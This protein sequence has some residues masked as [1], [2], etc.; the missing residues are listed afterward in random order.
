MRVGRSGP[1]LGDVTARAVEA[2]PVTQ[3]PGTESTQPT[4]GLHMYASW[5]ASGCGSPGGGGV[6]GPSVGE[7][8]ARGSPRSVSSH[9]NEQQAGSHWMP[10]RGCRGV[11]SPS[12]VPGPALTAR[13]GLGHTA[14]WDPQAPTL[15]PQA[16]P[17]QHSRRAVPGPRYPQVLLS[18]QPPKPPLRTETPSRWRKCTWTSG[19]SCSSW[20]AS[21]RTRPRP[22]AV[23]VPGVPPSQPP[24][25][26]R[27]P[28]LCVSSSRGSG[29]WGLWSPRPPGMWVLPGSVCQRRVLAA[30]LCVLRRRGAVG[31]RADRPVLPA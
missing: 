17:S 29:S 21:R 6:R 10:V 26:P 25:R 4:A 18:F 7:G 30:L 27:A 1:G 19:S 31:V 24:S 2:L 28:G 14:L 12:R 3:V 22:S 11:C 9:V 13:Q 16:P 8:R 23:S 5:A 20:P 15:G